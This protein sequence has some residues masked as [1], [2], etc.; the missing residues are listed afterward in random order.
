MT[1]ANN[2]PDVYGGKGLAVAG[3]IMGGISFLG[4]LLMLIL[5]VA[6]K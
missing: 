5:V 3:L 6:S 4:T 1:N 2:N